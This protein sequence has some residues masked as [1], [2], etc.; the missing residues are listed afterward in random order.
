MAEGVGFEPTDGLPHLLISSQVPLTTQPPFQPF[1][2]RYLR[3]FLLFQI[4]FLILQSDTV[5][6]TDQQQTESESIWQKTPYANL[7]RYVPSGIYFA[8]IRVQGKLIRRSLKTSTMSVAKLRLADLEKAERQKVEHQEAVNDGKMTFESALEIYR[9]RLNGNAALKPRSKVYR[10]ERIAAL[11]KSWPG[12]ESLDVRKINKTE[13][14][15][16]AAGFSK[17]AAPSNYNNTIGTLRLILDVAVEAGAIYDN[18]ARFI[19]RLRIQPK[20]LHLPSQAQFI[21]MVDVI[22]KSDGGWNHRCAALVQFL[23][24]GGFR[25]SEAANITW[26][27]CDFEKQG[28]VV[29][30]DPATGTK[31]WGIRRV[32]MIPE[33][34]DLLRGLRDQRPAEEA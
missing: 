21:S 3:R 5:R 16:W 28:I 2:I 1:I 22:R 14:L 6:V 23:A 4:D 26:T 7:L 15:T 11:I 33:M 10:E 13:C 20:R 25:K 9:G 31:N 8:R 29:R 19:K 24:F 34:V 27:D 17:N 32:P 12:L 30:G 18:A